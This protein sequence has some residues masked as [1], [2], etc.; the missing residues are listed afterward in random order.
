M[1]MTFRNP[2][3]AFDDAIR[4]G[5]LSDK[6]SDANYA[7]RYMYMGCR[8]DDVELFKHIDSRRYLESP[9]I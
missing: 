8:D 4:L 9:R 1:T 5:T 7:G 3:H 6:P 2:D